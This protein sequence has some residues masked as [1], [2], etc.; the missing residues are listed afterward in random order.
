MKVPVPHNRSIAT[1]L[2]LTIAATVFDLGVAGFGQGT[3]DQS[4]PE[5]GMSSDSRSS[6]AES[7]NEDDGR[8]SFGSTRLRTG[9]AQPTFSDE[10]KFFDKLYDRPSAFPTIAFDYS[11]IRKYIA[12]GAGLRGGYFTD[13]G[14]AAQVLVDNPTNDEVLVDS[15]GS[16]EITLI[17]VAA[18]ASIQLSPFPSKHIVIDGYGGVERLY[19]QEVRLNSGVETESGDEQPTAPL[20]IKGTRNSIITG[21]A[22]NI[23]LNDVDEKS[24]NS[25]RESLGIGSIYL[26]PYAEV[27]KGV[28][29]TKGA[30][31]DRTNVGIGFTFESSY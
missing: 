21:A 29:T 27:I 20:T 8:W 2:F 6:A 22:L 13:Q 30:N 15:N 25:M 7:N 17:P 24:V 14:H 23:L 12:V 19:F 9:F 28:G 16:T 26:S 18:V 10:L 5:I 3:S 31:F 11:F 4:A 1:T